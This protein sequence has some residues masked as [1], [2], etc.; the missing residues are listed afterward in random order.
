MHQYS[1]TTAVKRR[2][3]STGSITSLELIEHILDSFARYQ[4]Y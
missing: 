4:Y 3:A 1:A 2:Q